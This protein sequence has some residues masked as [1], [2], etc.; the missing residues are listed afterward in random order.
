MRRTRWENWPDERKLVRCDSS[1]IKEVSS[2]TG[3]DYC[4]P[5]V[6]PLSGYLIF[7]SSSKIWRNRQQNWSLTESRFNSPVKKTMPHY[8]HTPNP[9][10]GVVNRY[11][12]SKNH[13]PK[14]ITHEMKMTT[15]LTKSLFS[16]LTRAVAVKACTR[17]QITSG[18]LMSEKTFSYLLD[19]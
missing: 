3:N 8:G 13:S 7:S 17:S 19:P 1:F 2:E 11:P 4:L 10:H 14:S 6:V 15:L 12:D 5:A 16:D 9:L 18:L